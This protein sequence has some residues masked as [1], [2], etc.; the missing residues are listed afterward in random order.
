VTQS[1][2]FGVDFD[3]LLPAILTADKARTEL[4]KQQLFSGVHRHADRTP[5]DDFDNMICWRIS[6]PHPAFVIAVAGFLKTR[7]TLRWPRSRDLARGSRARS[8]ACSTPRRTTP[9]PTCSASRRRPICS[10]ARAR[11]SRARLTPRQPAR[12]AQQGLCEQST[13][14]QAAQADRKI[15]HGAG[16]G[17]RQSSARAG[18]QE[19]G[20]ALDVLA[21]GA[22]QGALQKEVIQQQGLIS[23]ES[24]QEQSDVY[25]K[26]VEASD[27]A[28][29]GSLLAHEEHLKAASMEKDAA[30]GSYIGAAIKGVTAI[31]AL[32]GPLGGGG[33][34]GDASGRSQKL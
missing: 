11:R 14:I 34:G 2:S 5:T 6:R 23:E 15:T 24:Y 3:H 18:L 26:M 12:A 29:Q 28:V 21:M 17:A 9:R 31:A 19:S 10:R 7:T 22:S 30:T 4:T 13:A 20:S 32:F 16:H 25:K 33:G 1:I 8:R 27:V